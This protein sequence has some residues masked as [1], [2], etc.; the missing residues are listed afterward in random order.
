M[1]IF[2]LYTLVQW[3]VAPS[4]GRLWSMVNSSCE[5]K[6][7][8]A[9]LSRWK[10]CCI[11]L[12]SAWCRQMMF[13]LTVLFLFGSSSTHISP[14]SDLETGTDVNKYSL[15]YIYYIYLHF[16][17]L[18]RMHS[19]AAYVKLWG[20]MHLFIV[21]VFNKYADWPGGGAIIKLFFLM[22][23]RGKGNYLHWWDTWYKKPFWLGLLHL[24][25][26]SWATNWKVNSSL[27]FTLPAI[28]C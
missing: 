12:H 18:M 13:C 15:I 19:L 25:M 23:H 21:S 17:V 24:Q 7:H 3:S 16:L 27:M 28:K 9:F 4:G 2:F 26:W 5:V 22:H 6:G 20:R 11:L 1:K 10:S 14:T 8:L